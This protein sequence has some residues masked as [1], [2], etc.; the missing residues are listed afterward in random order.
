MRGGIKDH[1]AAYATPPSTSSTLPLLHSP[2]LHFCTP[3]RDV[4]DRRVAGAVQ[5]RGGA[6]GENFANLVTAGPRNETPR[7][8]KQKLRAGIS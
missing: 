5:L 2:Y 4:T 3:P 7:A 8:Q 1:G 6:P